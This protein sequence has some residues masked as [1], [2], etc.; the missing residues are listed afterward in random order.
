MT[1]RPA[2]LTTLEAIN[3]ATSDALTTYL[4]PG[5]ERFLDSGDTMVD[6]IYLTT[7]S[8]FPTEKERAIASAAL[9]EQPDKDA[10]TD[11]LWALT[12]TPEFLI[13][14]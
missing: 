1:S 4:A 10:I 6:E 5:A 14:R 8:R 11:L 7:L 13:I 9:G 12:M 3:L 2:D